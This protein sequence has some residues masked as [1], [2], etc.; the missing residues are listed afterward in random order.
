MKKL[1]I[2]L[3]FI[4]LSGCASVEI[5]QKVTK[6]PEYEVLLI[7][8]PKVAPEVCEGMEP[9]VKQ[10]FEKIANDMG[11]VYIQ[12]VEEYF[13]GKNIFKHIV[14]KEAVA[15]KSKVLVL[16]ST[17]KEIKPGNQALRFVMSYLLV[18]PGFG[19][20][21]IEMEFKLVDGATGS[22][23]DE[24]E[25]C[26]DSSFRMGKFEGDISIM[27]TKELANDAGEFIENYMQSDLN[28]S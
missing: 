26:R 23:I 5:A 14:S 28:E 8:P 20:P 17:F 11:V 1:I 12:G 22:T 27:Y 16:E 3:M 4:L 7:S 9:E 19:K 18:I 15:D 21:S 10:A 6:Y 24:Q 25:E 13:V 2:T